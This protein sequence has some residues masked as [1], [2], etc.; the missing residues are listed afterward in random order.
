MAITCIAIGC[1]QVRTRREAPAKI[2]F[3][4][5]KLL[6]AYVTKDNETSADL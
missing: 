2:Q 5:L 4:D 1:P 3:V 6:L